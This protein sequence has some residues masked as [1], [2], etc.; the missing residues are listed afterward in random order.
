MLALRE[1]ICPTDF[2]EPSYE[3]L[4]VALALARQFGPDVC[5]VHVTQPMQQPT[6]LSTFPAGD[7]PSGRNNS[8]VPEP[9]S[10]AARP[11]SNSREFGKDR[12]SFECEQSL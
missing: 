4:N 11:A 1:I 6:R 12:L 9:S 8:S 3:D 7:K 10:S 5:L 2:S